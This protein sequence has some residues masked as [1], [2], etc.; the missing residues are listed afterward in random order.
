MT[1]TTLPWIA[2]SQTNKTDDVINGNLGVINS[3]LREKSLD[4]VLRWAYQATDKGVQLLPVTSF[5]PSGLVILHRM[6]QLGFLQKVVSIDTL[7][8]FPETYIFIDSWKLAHESIPLFIYKPKWFEN[9]QAF[10]D[11]FG[12][13]FYRSNPYMYSQISKV[14]PLRRALVEHDPKIWITGRRRS[15]GGERS[16]LEILELDEQKH[17]KLNPLAY[18]SSDDVW[19]YIKKY[20]IPYNSLHDQGFTSIGD[21]MTTSYPLEGGG[22]RSGRFLGFSTAEC[23]CHS[24]TIDFL[25]Y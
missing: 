4:D 17:M 20:N 8:L 21:I 19:N 12:A 6:E 1:K 5:G 13:D 9:K 10:D 2:D 11:K 23:G 25:E 24:N 15:Q 14:E 18:W 7:H 16:F 22:E 3:V